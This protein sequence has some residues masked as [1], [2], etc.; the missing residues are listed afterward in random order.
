MNIFPELLGGNF[1]HLPTQVQALH[2][3]GTSVWRGEAQ[4]IRGKSLLGRVVAFIFG[5]PQASNKVP[6]AVSIQADSNGERWERNF[7]GKTFVS[8]LRLG[9][10]RYQGYMLERFGPIN[11][12]LEMVIQ[13]EK[14]YFQPRHWNLLGMPLPKFLIPKEGSYE[15]EKDNT[16]YFDVKLEAPVVGLIV[17][18]KGWLRMVEN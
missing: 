8:Q 1:Q 6:V 2:T 17:A 11:V 16:F 4:V 3:S 10:G 18:Y 14:L 13:D 7:A 5:F 12:A 9:K 15:Y